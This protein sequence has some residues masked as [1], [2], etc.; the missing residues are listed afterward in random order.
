MS[1]YVKS[2]NTLVGTV[3]EQK[4]LFSDLHIEVFL[5]FVDGVF[6]VIFFPFAYYLAYI[7]VKLNYI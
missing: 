6:W 1:H 7:Y 5:K 3:R 4:D 2:I